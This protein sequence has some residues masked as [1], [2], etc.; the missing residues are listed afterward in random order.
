MATQQRSR[1][2]Y[3]LGKNIKRALVKSGHTQQDLVEYSGKDKGHISKWCNDK[4]RPTSQNLAMIAD[5]TGYTMNEILS[6]SFYDEMQKV[7]KAKNG[8]VSVSDYAER[9]VNS[10]MAMVQDMLTNCDSLAVSK[11]DRPLKLIENKIRGL[12]NTFE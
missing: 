7:P 11:N 10:I 1:E 9:E 8:N 4:V 2:G 6:G 12:V 3:S 5:F